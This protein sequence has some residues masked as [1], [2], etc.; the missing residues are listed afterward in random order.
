MMPVRS[1]VA[2]CLALAIAL[3]AVPTGA[4]RGQAPAVSVV[5]I[6]GADGAASLPVDAAGRPVPRS[7]HCP[8][9][10]L[11]G[12]ATLVAA[13]ALPV[14]PTDGRGLR[15][16]RIRVGG[17]GRVPVTLRARGPPVRP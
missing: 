4:A 6:C 13:T 17:T 10:L 2:L 15:R 8:D 11:L 1:L 14:R 7:H 9:C 16:S 12:A 5:T 3:G